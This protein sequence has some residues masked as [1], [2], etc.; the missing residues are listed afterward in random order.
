[1]VNSNSESNGL[2]NSNWE[3]NVTLSLLVVINGNSKSNDIS[4][5]SCNVT[6][7]PFVVKSKSESKSNSKSKSNSNVSVMGM[8]NLVGFTCLI[9]V[10]DALACTVILSL[11]PNSKLSS[12]SFCTNFLLALTTK[13]CFRLH[14]AAVF[15]FFLHYGSVC[16]F[17]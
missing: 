16:P 7:L 15:P 11:A 10:C 6:F 9:L 3:S 5:S 13:F 4:S 1:M 2:S 14:C 12:G 8:S 17:P